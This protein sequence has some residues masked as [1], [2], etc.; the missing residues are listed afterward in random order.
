M[1]SYPQKSTAP[2]GAEGVVPGTAREVADGAGPRDGR[3]DEHQEHEIDD[4]EDSRESL[5][6]LQSFFGCGAIYRNRRHDDHREDLLRWC[7]RR[8]ADLEHR[9]VPVLRAVPLRT[10]KARD[11]AL[12]CDVLDLMRGD[13]HL[14][15]D[16]MVEI[17]RIAQ[18]MN[19]KKPSAFLSFLRDCTPAMSA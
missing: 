18:A 12:F 16:G 7:V 19:R 4:R 11:F 5:E 3:Q 2:T 10:A 14:S 9:V 8:R 17:A 13:R 15:L 1:K 6:L